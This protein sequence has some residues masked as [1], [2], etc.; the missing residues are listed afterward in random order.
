IQARIDE[1]TDAV[2]CT[3]VTQSL[4]NLP[5]FFELMENCIPI[6]QGTVAEACWQHEE[7]I[8]SDDS[9]L[10][11]ITRLP[12]TLTRQ[13]NSQPDLKVSAQSKPPATHIVVDNTAY[14]LGEE[15]LYLHPNGDGSFALAVSK[16]TEV[17]ACLL[18]KQKQVW[19]NVEPGA[20]VLVND[21]AVQQKQ[22]LAKGDRLSLARGG[23]QAFLIEVSPSY[24]A[25]T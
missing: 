17:Q 11:F 20:T 18:K 9:S 4:L 22:P 23:P 6:P 14:A 2:Q 19:L 12:A 7:I 21:V 16:D 25:Q 15:A 24:G 1:L 3:L 5:G 13:T 10:P 8:S